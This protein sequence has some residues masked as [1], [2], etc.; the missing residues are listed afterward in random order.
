MSRRAKLNGTSRPNSRSQKLH[1]EQLEDRLTP[2]ITSF[3]NSGNVTFSGDNSD[4]SLTLTQSADGY[5]EHNLAL[6]GNLVS[7]RD[8]DSATVGEQAALLS[9]IAGITIVMGSG[10]DTVDATG[11]SHSILVFGGAGNDVLRGG[12][13][14]D[15][16]R[17]GDGD[18]VLEGNG[19]NDT[20]RGDGY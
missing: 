16:L 8:L 1:V 13:G 12:S 18:D 7:R 5:L 17:G 3:L 10:N 14:N 11:L 6:G 4:N 20:L 19:G 2:T 9:D 15:D